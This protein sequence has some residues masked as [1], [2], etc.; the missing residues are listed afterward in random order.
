MSSASETGKKKDGHRKRSAE[1]STDPPVAPE[2]PAVPPPPPKS[3]PPSGDGAAGAETPKP[4]RK[5]R[6]HADGPVPGPSD[7]GTVE[8]QPPPKKPTSEAEASDGGQRSKGSNKGAD[9]KSDGAAP[10]AARPPA[11]GGGGSADERDNPA[12]IQQ[13]R[14]D[15]NRLQTEL[16]ALAKENKQL[17]E[18]RDKANMRT[19]QVQEELNRLKADLTKQQ[20][21]LQAA[22]KRHSDKLGQIREPVLTSSGDGAQITVVD[23]VDRAFARVA[24]RERELCDRIRQHQ[25]KM[26]EVMDAITDAL[27]RGKSEWDDRISRISVAIGAR[28]A[29][30]EGLTAWL[31]RLRGNVAV[32]EATAR[33]RDDQ[34]RSLE[35][36]RASLTKQLEDSRLRSDRLAHEKAHAE[37][38]RDSIKTMLISQMHRLREANERQFA[39]IRQLHVD[40]L[41]TLVETYEDGE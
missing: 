38:E 21:E 24:D 17:R 35:N 30:V 3:R 7:P 27:G 9:G 40:E 34:I 10:A 12:E 19:Q 31:D 36:I 1:G 18:E 4:E 20:D 25:A 26:A 33:K 2:P 16:D 41:R 6:K 32:L 23:L 29:E 13:L 5:K 8:S 28:K 14:E 37:Q 39:R 22:L 15:L 11:E